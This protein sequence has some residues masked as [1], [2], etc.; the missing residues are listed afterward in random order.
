M[1]KCSRCGADLEDGKAYCTS[2]GARVDESEQ[3][4]GNDFSNMM[5]KG[6][7]FS[8]EFDARDI[9]ENKVFCILSYLGLLFIIGLIAQPKSKVIKFHANQGLVLFLAEM[10]LGVVTGV[11]GVLPLAGAIL[12]GAAGLATSVLTIGALIYQIIN[13]S[14]GKVKKLPVIGDITIIKWD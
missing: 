12:A 11:V 5:N 14:E 6:K 10:V 7:D 1:A 8:G 2:C 9:V 3:K 13:I 4:K